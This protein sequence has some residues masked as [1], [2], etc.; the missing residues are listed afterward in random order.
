MSR[1]TLLVIGVLLAG[2]GIANWVVFFLLDLNPAYEDTLAMLA[3]LSVVLGGLPALLAAFR[4]RVALA[5]LIGVAVLLGAWGAWLMG[6]SGEDALYGFIV[7][8]VDVVLVIYGLAVIG[9]RK[10]IIKSPSQ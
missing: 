7:L 2:V 8:L 3:L 6:V 4:L 10:L 1:L 9:L 5:I